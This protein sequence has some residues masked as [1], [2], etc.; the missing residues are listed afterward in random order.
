MTLFI[1]SSKF[2]PN[3]WKH[4]L[5]VAGHINAMAMALIVRGVNNIQINCKKLII[6][7]YKSIE[8]I[9]DILF[10]TCMKHPSHKQPSHQHC[11]NC[12]YIRNIFWTNMSQTR[13]FIAQIDQ[14]SLQLLLKICLIA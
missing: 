6:I 13:N 3:C 11:R 9:L 10:Y 4:H 12:G 5:L 8:Y 14:N 1:I 2:I 7:N